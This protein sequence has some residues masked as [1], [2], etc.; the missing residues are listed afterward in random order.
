MLVETYGAEVELV[1]G[2]RASF[3]IIVDGETRYSK[4]ATGRFPDDGEVT[5]LLTD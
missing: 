5:N 3:E 4:L 2:A 1:S